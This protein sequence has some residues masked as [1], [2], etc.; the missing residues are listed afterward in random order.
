MCENE[1]LMTGMGACIMCGSRHYIPRM[2]EG[3]VTRQSFLW[4]FTHQ[5]SNEL[6]RC[7]KNQTLDV[8]RIP[9]SDR[10]FKL[11]CQYQ[12]KHENTL[13]KIQCEH[14]CI[15]A[16]WHRLVQIQNEA[17]QQLIGYTRHT[18]NVNRYTCKQTQ[19]TLHECV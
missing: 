2:P 14:I 13:D 1:S 12:G 10:R 18:F 15:P 6:L 4:I 3:F 16:I 7:N 17:G 9:S 8:I 5:Q 19:H 11:L